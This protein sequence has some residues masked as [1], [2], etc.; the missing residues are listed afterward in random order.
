MNINEKYN[1]RICENDK[2]FIKLIDDK[3]FNLIKCLECGFI[4]RE[5]KIIKNHPTGGLE[6]NLIK[7]LNH[8]KKLYNKFN[9]RFRKINYYKKIPGKILDIGCG[10]GGFLDIAREKGWDIYGVDIDATKVESCKRKGIKVYQGEIANI[11]FAENSLDVV[12]MF[13]TLEHIININQTLSEIYRILKYE[14]LLVIEIPTI[15]SLKAKIYG[16]HWFYVTADHI[17]YFTPVLLRKILEKRFKILKTKFY[18][19]GDVIGTINMIFHKNINI[20]DRLK[21]VPHFLL[22]IKSIFEMIFCLPYFGDTLIIYA[23][24]IK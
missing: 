11:N 17:N 24:K 19:T 7:N 9:K 8:Q 14:G 5:E 13:H 10:W 4:F 1:C 20:E 22:R 3:E 15:G 16:R 6:N 2:N 12:C 21:Y 18:S 23:Q